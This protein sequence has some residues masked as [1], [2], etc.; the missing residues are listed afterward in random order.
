MPVI[1][2]AGVPSP[3]LDERI[4][5]KDGRI[6]CYAEFGDPNGEPVIAFHGFPGCRLEPW[7]HHRTFVGHSVRLIS[8]DRPGSG[9]STFQPDRVVIDYPKDVVELA[10]HLGTEQF[11]ILGISG[12]A[13]YAVSCA[14][15]LPTERIS[16]VGL[17]APAPPW[18][19]DGQ[20]PPSD[21]LRMISRLGD[22]AVRYVP[23]LVSGVL[24]IVIPLINWGVKHEWIIK[25]IDKKLKEESTE[26]RKEEGQVC[27]LMSLGKSDI[28]RGLYSEVY[29][30]ES[31][32]LRP[33]RRR[34]RG[35][36]LGNP[37]T[38]T[39]DSQYPLRNSQTGSQTNCSRSPT[40]SPTVGIR[41]SRRR[42][43]NNDMARHQRR[44]CA[45]FPS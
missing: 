23:W 32:R 26:K 4:T 18:E 8:P 35:S 5:L 43:P 44:Q 25:K 31:Q 33:R 20:G 38:T 39:P 15:Y 30:V 1:R 7:P 22:W 41:P 27:G 36:A 16:V 34:R 29:N 40:P 9:N 45:H 12:G 13:P 17:L 10:D 37:G 2:V 24:S 28:R 14:N 3:R 6:L 11:G 19:I 21:G 42:L